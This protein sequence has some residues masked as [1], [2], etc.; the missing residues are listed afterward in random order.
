MADRLDMPEHT[1]VCDALAE[2][3]RLEGELKALD[4]DP[5]VCG[6]REALCPHTPVARLP[7]QE[8]VNHFREEIRRLTRQ[9]D[10]LTDRMIAAGLMS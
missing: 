7:R 9:R 10:D 3:E 6:C 2:I 1:L 5:V 8:L 4:P